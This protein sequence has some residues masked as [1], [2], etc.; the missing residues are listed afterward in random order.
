MSVGAVCSQLAAA[1]FAV[2][3]H[4]LQSI[5][6]IVRPYRVQMHAA[7]ASGLLLLQLRTF[8][9][10]SFHASPCR[11]WITQRQASSRCCVTAGVSHLPCCTAC[12]C[13][14]RTA[15]LQSLE[16]RESTT[17]KSLR[18]FLPSTRCRLSLRLQQPASARQSHHLLLLALEGG[19]RLQLLRR[20]CFDRH[21]LR[22]MLTP[23]L[24]NMGW[25][26]T[27]LVAPLIFSAAAIC[28]PGLQAATP[29]A[30]LC[31]RQ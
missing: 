31:K 29:A 28:L 24:M 21:Q 13:V 22:V 14:Y 2:R 10:F 27:A 9:C 12:C 23:V 19:G 8:S 18:A 3:W 4:R 25:T 20:R 30:R 15:W 1:D 6:C 16:P 11:S 7:R 26:Q 5:C 17:P